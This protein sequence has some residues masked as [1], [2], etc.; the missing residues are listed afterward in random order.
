MR[1]LTWQQQVARTSTHAQLLRAIVQYLEL[2]GWLVLVTP[3]GGVP[4]LAGL[5]DLLAF[6]GARFLP[7]EVKA[8]HDKKSFN[9]VIM[10]ERLAAAGFPVLVARSLDD[11]MKAAA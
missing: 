8:G 3:R 4:G 6:K 9:Q 1:R 11:V 10:A 5:P 2:T 7:V